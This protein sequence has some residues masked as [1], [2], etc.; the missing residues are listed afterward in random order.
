VLAQGAL[1]I[2]ISVGAGLLGSAALTSFLTTILFQI[3]PTDPIIFCALATLLAGVAMLACLAPAPRATRVDPHMSETFLSESIA[4]LTRTAKVLNDQLRNLP[5]PWVHNK[6]DREH[7]SPFDC[8]GHFI[9]GEKT[10]WMPRVNIIR[11]AP[12]RR[13]VHALRSRTI[14][15]GARWLLLGSGP[16]PCIIASAQIL[17]IIEFQSLDD[18]AWI[19]ASEPECESVP[20]RAEVQHLDEASALEHPTHSPA[21]MY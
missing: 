16:C 15:T 12:T 21:R 6:D 17:K 5:E 8:V 2:A 9:H 1:T 19:S 13:R 18:R 20:A 4:I 14:L 3:A 11:K 10:D 7:W